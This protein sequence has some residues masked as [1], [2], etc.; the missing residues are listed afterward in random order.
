MFS[1]SKHCL[2]KNC[3]CNQI[4]KKKNSWMLQKE[5]NYQ[6]KAYVQNITLPKGVKNNHVSV[7]NS[8]SGF[9]PFYV[10][11]YLFLVLQALLVDLSQDCLCWCDFPIEITNITFE[12]LN[13]WLEFG[14]LSDCLGRT[15][16]KDLVQ[17]RV[18]QKNSVFEGV[19]NPNSNNNC[20][21]LFCWVCYIQLA[22]FV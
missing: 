2:I 11:N 4:F 14:H 22:K 7:K 16:L 18:K 1:S 20:L 12:K 19:I 21:R 13:I 10:S 15:E 5:L 17:S 3:I 6:Q 8:I 9:K